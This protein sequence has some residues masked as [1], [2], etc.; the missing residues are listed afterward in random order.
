MSSSLEASTELN[1]STLQLSDEEYAIFLRCISNLKEECN[2]IDINEGIIR[3]R[4]NDK[5]SIFQFDLSPILDNISITISDIKR[6][7]E[8]LKIFTG[9][10]VTFDI[11]NGEGG[12]FTITDEYST[13]TFKTPSYQFIDNKYMSEEDLNAIF[14]LEDNELIIEHDF[15]KMITER[16]KQITQNFNIKSIQ[17]LFDED[18]ALI[19]TATQAK[20]LLAEF[21]TDIPTNIILDKCSANLGTIPFNIDHDENLEFKMYKVT[22]Q[23]IALNTF[24]TLLEDCD[25]TIYTRSQLMQDGE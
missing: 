2:D 17:V 21:A 19:K 9:H 24:K 5:T 25:I 18:K 16:I 20:D 12:Y 3:Q 10:D 11:E 4:S 22:D 7:Y 13:I 6:K 15:T 8:L 1:G 23:D 14:N